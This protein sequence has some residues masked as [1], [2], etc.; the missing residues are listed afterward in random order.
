MWYANLLT[1]ISYKPEFKATVQKIMA[2]GTVVEAENMTQ[3]MVSG[4][5]KN[6]VGTQEITVTYAGHTKTFNVIVNKK[7]PTLD[8][9]I[10]E[11]KDVTYNGSEQGI[12][13]S[14]KQ[15][16]VGLGNIVVKY[17]GNTQVPTNANTYEV[18]VLIEEG[19]NYNVLQE[20]VLGN[21]TINKAVQNVPAISLD[22]QEVKMTETAPKLS[23]SNAP[24]ENG[25]VSYE[26]DNNQVADNTRAGGIYG[27]EYAAGD[28][29]SWRKDRSIFEEMGAV[30]GRRNCG[31]ALSA[32][33]EHV[34]QELC[35]RMRDGLFE[36]W[37]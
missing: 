10:Y 23:L 4:Y 3:A 14:N 11:I 5:D 32:F 13:V 26:S 9:I 31:T 2:S 7:N 28:S 35:R 8:D 16:I 12:I 36:N 17:N 29:R 25:Q 6:T 30:R 18:S 33:S 24:M 15:G 19:L 22:K 1:Q 37:K 34:K 27:W 21:Y 20:V